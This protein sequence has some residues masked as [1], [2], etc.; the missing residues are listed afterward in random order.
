M[1]SLETENKLDDY[2]NNFKLK[3]IKNTPTHI[4]SKPVTIKK[5]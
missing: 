1:P 2:R 4:I 3:S 5:K